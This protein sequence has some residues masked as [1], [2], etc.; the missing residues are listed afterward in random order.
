[1]SR[2]PRWAWLMMPAFVVL[3]ACEHPVSQAEFDQLQASFNDLNAR[4]QM[5]RDSLHAYLYGAPGNPAQ[6]IPV[7]EGMAGV[8]GNPPG[9]DVTQGW[10]FRVY[11]A[12]CALEER[13]YG[14]GSS[15]PATR[16]CVD[17]PTTG[18]SRPPPPPDGW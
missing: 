17:G 11:R 9:G 14:V 7:R 5:L 8:G 3:G 12:L 16:L 15:G 2:I 4:H 13:V 1:M 6:G 18:G 10:T